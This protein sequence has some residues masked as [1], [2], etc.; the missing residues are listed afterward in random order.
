MAFPIV[1]VGASLAGANAPITLRARNGSKWSQFIRLEHHSLMCSANRLARSWLRCIVCRDHPRRC[2]RGIRGLRTRR[3]GRHERRAA[4][5]LRFRGR[6]RRD[7]TKYRSRGRHGQPDREWHPRGRAVPNI[8][9]RRVRGRRRGGSLS[10]DF[11]TAH[12]TGGC[13]GEGH[14]MGDADR[15]DLPS[16]R[17]FLSC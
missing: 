8:R 9:G 15:S 13:S 7:R 12:T 1:I 6:R 14:N 16:G 3:A 17:E 10:P 11:Q 5:R 2:C 4:D